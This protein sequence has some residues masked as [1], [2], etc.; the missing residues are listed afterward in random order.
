MAQFDM[1]L[2]PSPNGTEAQTQVVVSINRQVSARF[3]TW[4]AGC[5]IN[6]SAKQ[7]RDLADKLDH[8]AA[9]LEQMEADAASTDQEKAS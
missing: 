8:A 2:S 4:Q 1:T 7:A 5:W 9:T 3:I 6:M